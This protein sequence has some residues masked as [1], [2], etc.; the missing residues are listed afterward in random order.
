MNYYYC[1]NGS[2]ISEAGI[3]A[4]YSDALREKHAGNPRPICGCGCGGPAVHNDHTIAKSRCKQLHKA[5]LIWNP[6]NFESSCAIAHDQWEAF[7]SGMWILH[8]NCSKRLLFLKEHDP[9]GFTVRITL[10]QLALEEK[11]KEDFEKY[12]DYILF[13]KT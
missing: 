5:E 2:K 4:R 6:E 9:E 11:M 8:A 12:K 3:R 1:S 7:K 10:T 13:L